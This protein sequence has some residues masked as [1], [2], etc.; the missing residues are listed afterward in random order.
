MF[1]VFLITA[2]LTVINKKELRIELFDMLDMLVSSD[3]FNLEVL[4]CSN[5]RTLVENYD[6]IRNLN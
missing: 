2:E 3:N 6:R 4:T 1:W 5:I